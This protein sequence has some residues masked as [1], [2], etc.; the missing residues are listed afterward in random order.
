MPDSR[1]RLTAPQARRIARAALGLAALVL[2]SAWI[3]MLAQGIA[4]AHGGGIEAEVTR[5][6]TATA[7]VCQPNASSLQ[8]DWWCTGEIAWHGDVD[9]PS[10]VE[11]QQA[12]YD[13]LA[14]HDVTGQTVTVTGHLP[15]G[16]QSAGS[17][18]GDDPVEVVVA[19]GHPVG[20]SLW[21]AVQVWSAPAVLAAVVAVG[22]LLHH[23]CR[24]VRIRRRARAR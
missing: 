15:M 20:D 1:R 17:W 21:W 16:W 4:R 3:L 6:G 18:R 2:G 9:L 13:I 24:K 8:L 11:A 19:A 7:L 5:T 22:L 14:A 12:P 10:R 23:G